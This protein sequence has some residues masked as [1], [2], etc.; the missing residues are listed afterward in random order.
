MSISAMVSVWDRGPLDRTQR[1]VLLC[2]ADYANEDYL[3]WPSVPRIAKR[4]VMSPR[5]VRYIVKEMC[6][7]GW[8]TEMGTSPLRTKIYRLNLAPLATLHPLQGAT[9]AG[10]TGACQPCN[11]QHLDPA[12]VAANPLD[13]PSPI[14]GSARA[15]DIE[16]SEIGIE[17]WW[18]SDDDLQAAAVEFGGE[19]EPA[20]QRAAKEAERFRDY[21]KARGTKRRDWSAEFR[22]WISRA[23]DAGRN[24]GLRK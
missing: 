3:A 9:G 5:G 20:I 6:Q 15:R 19:F 14:L 12:R 10:A 8:L 4:C 22:V 16:Q 17:G 21:H 11:P 1:F 13:N 24:L 2:L 23:R 7:A 18:P